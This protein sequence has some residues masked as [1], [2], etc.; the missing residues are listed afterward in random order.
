MLPSI[1]KEAYDGSLLVLLKRCRQKMFLILTCFARA[2]IIHF[3]CT[4][5]SLGDPCLEAE[6]SVSRIFIR[7]IQIMA[8]FN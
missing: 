6:P 4:R 3:R 7:D 1:N 8:L 2:A 5:E